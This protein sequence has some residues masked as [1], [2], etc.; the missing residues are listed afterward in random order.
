[1]AGL[2]F[3]TLIPPKC[4][5][6]WGSNFENSFEIFSNETILSDFQT[7]WMTSVFKKV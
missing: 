6:N 7:L 3:G 4:S 1:M 2:N 5:E